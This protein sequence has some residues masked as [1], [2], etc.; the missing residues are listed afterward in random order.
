M[1][2][3]EQLEQQKTKALETIERR[4]IAV[5]LAGNRDFRKLILEYFCVEECARYA[6][7]SGDPALDARQQADALAMAQ[8][9][10]HLKRFLSLTIQFGDKCCADMGEL[11]EMLDELRAED[12]IDLAPIATDGAE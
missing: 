8:A 3:I 2:S 9:A 5:R 11:E 12:A 4:D 10:G 7:E 1:A 6:R